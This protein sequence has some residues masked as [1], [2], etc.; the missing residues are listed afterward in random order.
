MV[1]IHTELF[2]Q[3]MIRTHK[4]Q[5]KFLKVRKVKIHDTGNLTLLDQN[6]YAEFFETKTVLIK[7]TLGI[8]I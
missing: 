4:V 1:Y 8:C 5:T 6:I 7:K 3:I 2:F